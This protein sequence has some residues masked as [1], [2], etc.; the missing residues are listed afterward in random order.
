MYTHIWIILV[1][2]CVWRSMHIIVYCLL[3]ILQVEMYMI[4]YDRIWYLCCACKNR[5]IFTWAY[6]TTGPRQPSPQLPEAPLQ[7]ARVSSPTPSPYKSRGFRNAGQTWRSW[8]QSWDRGKN[9]CCGILYARQM[10]SI[11]T[12]LQ[13]VQYVIHTSD[14]SKHTRYT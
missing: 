6:D 1:C 10:Q 7:L 2:V 5:C 4:D 14:Q 11:H 8:K 9:K 12:V 13:Y 3:G